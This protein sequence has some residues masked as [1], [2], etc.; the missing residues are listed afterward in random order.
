MLHSVKVR[1]ALRWTNFMLRAFQWWVRPPGR[2][3]RSACSMPV[4]LPPAPANSSRSSSG[5]ARFRLTAA[6]QIL[7]PNGSRRRNL[8]FVIVRGDWPLH[9]QQRLLNSDGPHKVPSGSYAS[10]RAAL[11]DPKRTSMQWSQ[12]GLSFSKGI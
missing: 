1:A 8:P 12:S 4:Q 5:E 7:Q 6:G 10:R 11:R 9:V 3:Q 2:Q